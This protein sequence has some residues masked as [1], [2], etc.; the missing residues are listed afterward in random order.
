MNKLDRESF[1]NRRRLLLAGLLLVEPILVVGAASYSILRAVSRAEACGCAPA[2]GLR[3]RRFR[4][5]FERRSH[6]CGNSPNCSTK[7]KSCRPKSGGQIYQAQARATDRLQR[8]VESLLDFRT[9]MEAGKRP[10]RLQRLQAAEI[11][12]RV[13]DEFEK[14][15]AARGISFRA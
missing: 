5:S 10:Y 4:M 3:L 6:R 7:L 12:N 14:D 15:G 2:V 13:V 1:A 8:L 9:H 11:V